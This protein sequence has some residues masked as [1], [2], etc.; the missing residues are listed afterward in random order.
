MRETRRS[1]LHIVLVRESVKTSE[2]DLLLVNLTRSIH[3]SFFSPF[4]FVTQV[5]IKVQTSITEAKLNKNKF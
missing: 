3:K 2:H 1:A 4:T 5:E